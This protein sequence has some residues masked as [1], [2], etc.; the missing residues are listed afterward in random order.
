MLLN[1][2][3]L[4]MCFIQIIHQSICV[5]LNNITHED[6]KTLEMEY[7]NIM[8]VILKYHPYYIKQINGIKYCPL[9][10]S[11][12]LNN[13]EVAYEGIEIINKTLIEVVNNCVAYKK[14]ILGYA[15]ILN[16]IESMGFT[17]M[18]R[19]CEFAIEINKKGAPITDYLEDFGRILAKLVPILNRE[20]ISTES[21][22]CILNVYK[23][24]ENKYNNV[25]E[26][27]R[28]DLLTCMNL[29]NDK[30]HFLTEPYKES[31]NNMSINQL[32]ATHIYNN[33]I[34]HDLLILKID[35]PSFKHLTGDENQ[36]SCTI[37]KK[38][39]G[40][41]SEIHIFLPCGHGWCCRYCFQLM[42][43]CPDCHQEITCTQDIHIQ[44][45]TKIIG[46]GYR[47]LW[48][49]CVLDGREARCIECRSQI[50]DV[51]PSNRHVMRPCGHGWYC[52]NCISIKN[53]S[54]CDWNTTS[55]LC[56]NL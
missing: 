26:D 4:I 29:I 5:D 17:Y 43:K 9:P 6:V 34:I 2:V 54:A 7:P 48:P 21:Y 44:I 33:G 37:C 53:C 56:V 11:H 15:I 31:M 50:K 23:I 52:N 39:I 18:Y 28:N 22:E 20:I 41:F 36:T 19:F 12:T 49:R 24:H 42:T 45:P 1:K 55:T 25:D 27:Y 16:A 47:N 13:E 46:K 10:W 35:F 40:M 30:V 32:K 51:N 8:R 14:Y 38:N 3:K